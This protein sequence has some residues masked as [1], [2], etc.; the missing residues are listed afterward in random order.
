MKGIINDFSNL[1]VLVIGDLILDVYL[2]GSSSRISPEAPVPVVDV[3]EE[4]YCLGGAGNVATNVRILGAQVSFCSVGGNDF[5]AQKAMELLKENN[6]D[7]G[8]MVWDDSRDTIIKKRVVAGSQTLVRFDKGTTTALEDDASQMLIKNIK[9]AYKHCDVVILADYNK[10][11]FSTRVIHALA[12]LRNQK[13]V[14]LSIDS[15][16]LERFKI[17]SPDLVKPNY[18]EAVELLSLKPQNKNR[19][20]QMELHGEKVCSLTHARYAAITLDAEGAL[21]FEKTKKV[22]RVTA[23]RVAHPFVAGAGDTYI[24][25]FSLFMAAGAE[26][27]KAAQTAALAA[28]VAIQKRS[29]AHC[30]REELLMLTS[31][32]SK[33][34]NSDADLQKLAEIC[35]EQ[36]KK[37]VFTNGCFDILHSGHV[38]Y[39]NRARKLGDVMIVGVN[40]DDSIR[41]LKGSQR[42]INKLADRVEV[43]A[44]LHD[45]DYI[46]P[47][48][49]AGDDT[50]IDLIRLIKPD[51]FA[52]GGDYTKEK[53]PEADIVE[54]LGG[55]VTILP[56]IPDRSTTRV[57]SYIRAAPVL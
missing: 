19:V 11:T 14:F 44:A 6:I 57:I 2:K 45:V 42:P 49:K 26:I 38:Q 40:T 36:G 1:R 22:C 56:L 33:V 12:L 50:P 51:V 52:K 24:S 13:P 9:R 30:T 28:G 15:G 25:A 23:E 18:K 27:H 31:Y 39:L 43:I 32:G 3:A 8:F 46:V 53:L 17:L 21:I 47:F 10:G 48:G 54:S 34:I 37:I 35:H 20:K 4:K 41:R 16:H 7:D 55:K 29:T 5:G